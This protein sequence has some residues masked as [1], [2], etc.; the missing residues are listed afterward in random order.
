MAV[1]I[2]KK[3]QEDGYGHYPVCVAKTQSSFS[4]K[5]TAPFRAL[6]RRFLDQPAPPAASAVG[7]DCAAYAATHV[8]VRKD[9]FVRLDAAEQNLAK[10]EA[11]LRQAQ[12]DLQAMKAAADELQRCVEDLKFKGAL[13]H[14]LTDGRF[15]DDRF[16]WP[17]FARAEALVPVLAERAAKCEELRRVPDETLADF[18]STGLFRMLQPRRFGG[19]ELDYGDIVELRSEEHV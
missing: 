13:I 10:A 19:S 15:M 8:L 12:T 16:F 1:V 4:W 18:H 7:T 9:V 14:G 5:V 2:D 3:L 11:A 17:I 6:R